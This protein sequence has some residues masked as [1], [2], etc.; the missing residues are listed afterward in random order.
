MTRLERLGFGPLDHVAPDPTWFAYCE[1][2]AG[3]VLNRSV[4]PDEDVVLAPCVRVP[5]CS[6]L[7]VILQPL[8]QFTTLVFAHVLDVSRTI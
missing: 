2:P 5:R 1:V 3:F 4:V 6:R 8:Q 7:G